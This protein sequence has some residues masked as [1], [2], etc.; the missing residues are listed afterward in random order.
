MYD[1]GLTE[2]PTQ[3]I[4]MKKVLAVPG[5]RLWPEI[6]KGKESHAFRVHISNKWLNAVPDPYAKAVGVNGRKAM[7]IDLRYGSVDGWERDISAPYLEIR[8]MR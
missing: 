8:Q 1:D 4:Q 5:Q 3:I 2:T 7:I 6:I